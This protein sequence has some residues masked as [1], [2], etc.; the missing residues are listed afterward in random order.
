MR[1]A[2]KHI[3]NL[4]AIFVF[5]GLLIAWSNVPEPKLPK[6]FLEIPYNGTEATEYVININQIVKVQRHFDS[7][8]SLERGADKAWYIQIEMSSGKSIQ[9]YGWTDETFWDAVR[10]VD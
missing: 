10:K 5:L 7:A 2:C 8:A 3:T 4:V 9:L 1:K 6:G